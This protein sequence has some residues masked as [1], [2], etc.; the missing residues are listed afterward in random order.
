L[1]NNRSRS[2]SYARRHLRFFDAI[3]ACALL[4]LSAPVMALAALAIR[5]EG[6]GPVL[7]PQTR[8]GLNGRPFRM[9]KLRSMRCD[10]EA[11]GTPRWAAGNDPR[12]TRVGR[13]IRKT[14]IDELPQLINVL[15]GEMSLICRL[16]KQGDSGLRAQAFDQARHH[17]MGTSAL[18]L[19]CING[20]GGA[21]ARVRPLLHRTSKPAIRSAH[22][23]RD[24]TRCT[25]GPGGV[26][27]IWRLAD[28]AAFKQNLER[29][30]LTLL[31]NARQRGGPT[32]R[33][34]AFHRGDNDPAWIFSGVSHEE[35]IALQFGLCNCVRVC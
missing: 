14:R 30:Q 6:D 29:R 18:P 17:R 16:A 1:K 22:P 35:Q 10:A 3:T 26:L 34:K 7:Y 4:A 32:G 2:H 28:P 9:L 19:R 12:I 25:H 27:A 31:Q 21:Q 5:A 33:R 24:G 8:I 13:F 15:K 20:A 11:D 23:R